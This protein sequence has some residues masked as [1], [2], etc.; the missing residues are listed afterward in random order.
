MFREF[1]WYRNNRV[2]YDVIIDS[3]FEETKFNDGG[4]VLDTLIDCYE[5]RGLNVAGNVALF[6]KQE[7]ANGNMVSGLIDWS[8]KYAAYKD[9]VE[10]LLTLA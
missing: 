10:K 4:N 6:L 9:E 7:E 3:E 1:R 8:V 5:R 2:W